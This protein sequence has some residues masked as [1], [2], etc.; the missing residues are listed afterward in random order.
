MYIYIKSVDVTGSYTLGVS[1]K[2]DISKNERTFRVITLIS[3]LT[4]YF[5]ISTLENNFKRVNKNGSRKLWG[6]KNTIVS[7]ICQLKGF[8]NSFPN[9]TRHHFITPAN[10][11]VATGIN[12]KE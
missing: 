11:C 5:L 1:L 8:G 12:L 10:D 6:K 2:Y 7:A 4:N 9:F 3:W